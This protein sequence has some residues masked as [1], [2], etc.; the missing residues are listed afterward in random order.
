VSRIVVDASIA[1]KWYLEEDGSPVAEKLR[2]E[3]DIVAP[4]LVIAET[5]NGLWKA[6]R[7]KLVPRAQVDAALPRIPAA[8]AALAPLSGL[9]EAVWAFAMELD[10]PAYDTFYLALAVRENCAFATADVRLI[11]KTKGTRFSRLICPLHGYGA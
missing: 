1:L 5:I 2:T 7:R 9:A 3:N 8:F 6:V 10:H 11:E 4:E